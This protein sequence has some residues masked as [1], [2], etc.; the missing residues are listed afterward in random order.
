MTSSLKTRALK[1]PMT[2]DEHTSASGWPLG[3]SHLS[4]DGNSE[5][6]CYPTSGEEEKPARGLP[7]SGNRHSA[8]STISAAENGMEDDTVL[9]QETERSP[10]QKVAER[11]CGLSPERQEEMLRAMK[12]FDLY[13]YLAAQLVEAISFS[14]LSEQQRTDKVVAMTSLI[15]G[16]EPRDNAEKLLLTQMTALHDAAMHCFR[17]AAIPNQTPE[18]RQRNLNLAQKLTRNYALHLET[19]DRRRG[20]GQQTVRVEHVTVN[21]GGQ[22]IVGNVTHPS[23]GEGGKK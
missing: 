20:R 17:I 5:G 21:A 6:A 8:E 12:E 1:G 19:L 18:G 13:T 11:Q 22:A 14:G 3:D 16:M 9:L 23:G 7:E 10:L 15:V 4:Q 2:A